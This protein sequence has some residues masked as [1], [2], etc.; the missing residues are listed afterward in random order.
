M[1]LL[2]SRLSL[3]IE[4]SNCKSKHLL[5]LFK[6]PLLPKLRG[7]FA[8]FL[9]EDSF[10]RLRSI[11]LIYLCWIAVRSHIFLVRGFSCK[12][13][14]SYFALRLPITSQSLNTSRDFPPDASYGFERRQP[15]PRITYP[16][17]L[18]LPNSGRYIVQE[19]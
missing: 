10:V 17:P 14:I 13:G 15:K 8:E 11:L 2:N 6:A 19:Y 12:H 7:N 18:P 16:S 4:T 3:F 1:F 5:P 9:K